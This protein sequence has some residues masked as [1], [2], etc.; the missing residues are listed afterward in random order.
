MGRSAWPQIDVPDEVFGEH[1]ALHLRDGAD[2]LQLHLG[3]LYVACACAR[4][5]AQALAVL[6]GQ[7]LAEVAASVGKMGLG[8]DLFDEALQA[9]R[10]QLLTSDGTRLPAIASYAGR[11]DLR[12]WLRITLVRELL[13]QRSVARRHVPLEPAALADVA[14]ADHDPEVRYL[15]QTYG[16]EFKDAFAEALAALGDGDRALLRYQYVERLTIDEVA[17]LERVH[18]ATAAR[19][20][21]QARERLLER[22]RA[23]LRARLRVDSGELQSILRLIESQAQVSLERLLGNDRK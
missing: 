10:K 14:A 21:A 4:G 12:G 6:E 2:P 22:T 13:H 8:N 11:G 19:R 18:R 7:Y 3:D 15:K 1:I 5:E 20:L 16:A 9:T 17:V 23:V